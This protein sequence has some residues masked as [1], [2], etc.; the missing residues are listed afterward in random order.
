M[1]EIQSQGLRAFELVAPEAEVCARDGE[2]CLDV[3]LERCVVHRQDGCEC[4]VVQRALAGVCSELVN[5]A[6]LHP[7][8][9]G[10]QDGLC[11]ALLAREGVRVLHTQKI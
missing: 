2:Q 9:V 5:N 10:E 3:V 7:V 6:G 11:G 1:G 4:A 8:L